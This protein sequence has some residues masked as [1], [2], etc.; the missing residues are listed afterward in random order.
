MYQNM[1]FAT[2]FRVRLSYPTMLR[3]LD[4]V[5]MTEGVQS[6]MG[7]YELL[8]YTGL[9]HDMYFIYICLRQE[10]MFV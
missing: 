5:W 2:K 9:F 8:K 10:V 3:E 1:K 6:R 4:F 7:N